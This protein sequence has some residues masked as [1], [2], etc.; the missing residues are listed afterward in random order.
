MKIWIVPL[1]K[2]EDLQHFKVNKISVSYVLKMRSENCLLFGWQI[3]FV[4]CWHKWWLHHRMTRGRPLSMYAK[5]SEKLIFLTPW[6]VHVCVR[7]RGLEMLFFRKI[8]R[9]YLMDDP[10]GAFQRVSWKI[11][12]TLAKSIGKIFCQ[13]G[14]TKIF[15]SKVMTPRRVKMFLFTSLRSDF[16]PILFLICNNV[17]KNFNQSNWRYLKNDWYH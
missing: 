4:K 15:Y 14:V 8:L 6:Y 7:I 17:Y 13:T 16:A 9:T 10:L 1:I 5:F 11:W 2:D 12:R 3:V